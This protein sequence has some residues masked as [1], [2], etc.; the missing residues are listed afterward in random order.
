MGRLITIYNEAEAERNRTR[1]DLDMLRK[2]EAFPWF[3]CDH[4]GCGPFR[5]PH[6]VRDMKFCQ[7]CWLCSLPRADRRVKQQ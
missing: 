7:E 1:A 2:V 6:Y 3:W 5:Y 4:C